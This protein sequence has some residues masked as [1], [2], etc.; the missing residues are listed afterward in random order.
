MQHQFTQ[1]LMAFYEY[2]CSL[3]FKMS[4]LF[5]YPKL[6]YKTRYLKNAKS[7]IIKYV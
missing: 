6:F 1:L 3:L 4:Y 2:F 7:F 5:K